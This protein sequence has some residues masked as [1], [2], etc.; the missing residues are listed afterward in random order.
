[1]FMPLDHSADVYAM[2][3]QL[4]CEKQELVGLSH[5]ML[6]LLDV[7]MTSMTISG[8]RRGTGAHAFLINVSSMTLALMSVAVMSQLCQC[9]GSCPYAYGD[10]HMV[11]TLLNKIVAAL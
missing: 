5:Q 10:Y 8:R 2:A 1:M 4:S 7:I 6:E 11:T 3:C 9:N